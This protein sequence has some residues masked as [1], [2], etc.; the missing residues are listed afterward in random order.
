MLGSDDPTSEAVLE[1]VVYNSSGVV[2]RVPWRGERLLVG[3]HPEANL[4]LQEP[5]L[6]AFHAEIVERDGALCLRDLDSLNGTRLN[7]VRIAQSRLRPGDRIELGDSLIQVLGRRD[8]VAEDDRDGDTEESVSETFQVPLE[9]LRRGP[10]RA[11]GEDRRIL[12]LRDLF[13]ALKSLEDPDE[14]LAELGRVLGEAFAGARVFVLRPDGEGGWE[15]PESGEPGPSRTFVAEAAASESATLST[16]LPADQRF[17]SADS[18]RVGGILTAL[19][20]P[21]SCEGTPVGVVYVDRLGLP[22]FDPTDLHLLGIAVNHV[23]AVL[24]NASRIGAL[25]RT[26][27]ELE[28]ARASLAQLNR[29]LERLVHERTAEIRRQSEQIARLAEAKDELLGIA[30][31]DIRGP[32]TVIQGTIEVLRARGAERDAATVQRSLDVIHKATHGLT[33]LLGELLDA[34]AIETGKITLARRRSSLAELIEE[35]LPVPRLAAED[36]EIEIQRQVDPPDM[37]LEVDPRRLGQAITNLVLN[38]VKFSPRGSTIRLSARTLPGGATELK[39][40]D[41]GVGIPPAEIHRVFGPFEQGAAGRRVGGSGLGLMIAKRLVELHGG[42]LS[43]E[44]EEGVGSR[45]LMT[46][47]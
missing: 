3:R 33:L 24:E 15:V 39:V 46:L 36:K 47:P 32:L 19:A 38:A 13:E 43:V 28:D 18:V 26:N 5:T 45:F 1:L 37:A 31:H 11:L 7:G 4:R 20:A 22:P 12:L 10:D 14:V 8:E 9:E 34:R 35:A 27:A 16:W 21:V 6:S 25:R 44:S 41:Q 42:S 30:A 29:N 17:S 2:T 23:T 40:E